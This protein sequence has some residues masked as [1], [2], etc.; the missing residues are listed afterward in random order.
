MDR[1][2]TTMQRKWVFGYGGVRESED[3]ARAEREGGR[4]REG[5]EP[6]L[7]YLFGR[8]MERW[9]EKSSDWK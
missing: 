8:E 9:K 7:S 6:W 2:H 3:G 5:G 1:H 4:E